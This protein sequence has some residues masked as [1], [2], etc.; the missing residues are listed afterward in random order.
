MMNT[1]PLKATMHYELEQYANA[2][3][4]EARALNS[5]DIVSANFWREWKQSVL[6]T[7]HDADRILAEAAYK[8]A[9]AQAREPHL[10]KKRATGAL[11]I[12]LGNRRIA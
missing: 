10:A 11:P 8:R 4:Q 1:A 5:G 3:R 7:E 9:Y 6:K 12:V 2:G